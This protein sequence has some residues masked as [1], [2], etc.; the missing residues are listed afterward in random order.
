MPFKKKRKFGHRHV[1]HAEEK[2]CG[3]RAK[4]DL[5]NLYTLFIDQEAKI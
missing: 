1:A 3:D 2:P 5:G 4:R